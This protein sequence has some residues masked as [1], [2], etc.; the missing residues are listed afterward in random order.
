MVF[1][2]PILILQGRFN[3]V[4]SVLSP[5]IERRFP[6]STKGIGKHLPS[7]TRTRGPGTFVTS[8]HGRWM[9]KKR[10]DPRLTHGMGWDTSPPKEGKDRCMA[11]KPCPTTHSNRNQWRRKNN[12]TRNN[13]TNAY[14]FRTIPSSNT[15]G[16]ER[17]TSG[18]IKK[19]ALRA[20]FVLPSNHASDRLDRLWR[21][22]GPRR[23]HMHV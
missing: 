3:R 5:G 1:S 16:E 9:E 7:Q 10:N 6:T 2:F 21:A 22:R 23:T 13:E 11:G 19:R 8:P 4:D 18:Q 14:A 15:N 17:K 12:P 20:F